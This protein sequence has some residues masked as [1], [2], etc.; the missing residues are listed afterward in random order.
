MSSSLRLSFQ[1]AGVR[2]LRIYGWPLNKTEARAYKNRVRM[3]QI[4]DNLEHYF[5]RYCRIWLM[6]S[7]HEGPLPELYEQYKSLQIVWVVL[8]AV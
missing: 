8:Q 1:Q 6:S 2:R 3:D 7:V 4:W 5:L